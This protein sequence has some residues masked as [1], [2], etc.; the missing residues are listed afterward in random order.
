MMALLQQVQLQ[1]LKMVM[2]W[3]SR[4]GRIAGLA[5]CQVPCCWTCSNAGS[6]LAMRHHQLPLQTLSHLGL[7]G[8]QSSSRGSSSSL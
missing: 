2:K 1:A 7:A 3:S 4:S 8:N 6:L 5:A